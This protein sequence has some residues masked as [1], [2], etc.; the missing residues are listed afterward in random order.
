MK[1]YTIIYKNGNTLKTNANYIAW[2]GKQWQMA[3]N[4]GIT[5]LKADYIETIVESE[6]I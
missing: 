4:N 1:E 3:T 6:V 2:N 5:L